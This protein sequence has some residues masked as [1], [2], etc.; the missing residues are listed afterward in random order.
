LQRHHPNLL[1]LRLLAPESLWPRTSAIG[2]GCVKTSTT[3]LI[4]QCYVKC[5]FP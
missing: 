5:K 3:Q 2:S 1:K 4:T